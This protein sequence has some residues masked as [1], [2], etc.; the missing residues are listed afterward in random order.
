MGWQTGPHI[1]AGSIAAV[2]EVQVGG[3]GG[4]AMQLAPSLQ[5]MVRDSLKPWP[6]FQHQHRPGLENLHTSC[7]LASYLETELCLQWYH[8]KRFRAC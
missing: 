6:E 2:Y 7:Q 8:H 4:Q 1:Q 5:T 3:G